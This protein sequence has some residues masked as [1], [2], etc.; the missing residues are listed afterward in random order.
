MAAV[1]L[2]LLLQF[3]ELLLIALIAGQVHPVVLMIFTITSLL[4]M[5]LYIFIVAIFV[6]VLLSW[7]QPGAYNPITALM[8]QLTTPVLRPVQR[9]I[10]PISGLDLS[11][12][13]ALIVLNLL[14]MAIP[15]IER[16]LL[17]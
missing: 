1:T 9:A 12:L 3:T 8:Q 7:I 16:S 4:K 17:S 15:H 5:V 10:P 11:P 6:Q 13:V 14:V 2:L